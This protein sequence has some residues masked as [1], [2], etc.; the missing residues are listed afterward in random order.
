MSTKSNIILKIK[1][2]IRSKVIY[3]INKKFIKWFLNWYLNELL[4]F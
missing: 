1:K 2:L 3:I 4:R